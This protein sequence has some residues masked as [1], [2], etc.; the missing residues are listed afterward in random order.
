MIYNN[1]AGLFSSNITGKKTTSSTGARPEGSGRIQTA[2]QVRNL[3]PGQTMSGEVVGREGDEIQIRIAKDTVINAKMEQEVKM[4]TGQTVTFQVRSNSGGLLALR[5][6]FQN[7]AQEST[8]LRAL[9]QA[10]IEADGKSMQM[11]FSMMEEGMSIDRNSLQNM[12]RQVIDVPEQDIPAVVQMNRL[13]IPVTPENLVQFTA[14]K[15]YEHQLISS[16][17]QVAGEIPQAVLDIFASG[18]PQE[19]AAFIN[20]LLT[21][22]ERNVETAG[23]EETVPSGG[24]TAKAEAGVGT[25]GLV[26]VVAEGDPGVSEAV[27]GQPVKEALAEEMKLQS[28]QAVSEALDETGKGQELSGGKE[29]GSDDRIPEEDR[30]NLA[31]LVRKAGGGQELAGRILQG[32][33]GKEE[34]YRAVKELSAHTGSREAQEGVRDLF[35]SKG[36]QKIFQSRIDSQWMLTTPESVEKESVSR[37]YDRLSEQTKQLT[38]ALSEA[39]KADSPLFKTVENIK[40]NV[41]FMNQLNQTYTYVQLPLKFKGQNAH[42]E[43]YVYTNK[44]N[45]AKKDGT[46]SAFLHLDMEHLGMVD[47]Y[48]ALERG[49]INTNFYLEDEESLLLLEKNMDMLTKRLTEKGYQAD[50]KVILRQETGSVMDEIL[51]TDKNVSMIGSQSF[52]VRA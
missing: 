30:R 41:D 33:I 42:G 31:A 25:E 27:P 21:I 45:L 47:V 50:A 19:G 8:A 23:G 4:A 11:V 46:V 38:R 51:K 3:E 10:G 18:N 28:D 49:R 40:Q 20:Q 14:Y 17:A 15:N 9:A 52:D 26:K 44:K 34:L 32:E 43:L 37:L 5:P 13:N 35:L 2:A 36:F 6:L 24:E 39:V 1:L 22:F 48:V 7:M 12:Y 29:A 16:F